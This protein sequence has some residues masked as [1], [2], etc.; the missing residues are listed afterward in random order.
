MADLRCSF[1]D[2]RIE[3]QGD[4]WVESTGW[5]RKRKSGGLNQLRD[6]TPTGRVACHSCIVALQHGVKV[7]KQERLFDDVE[8]QQF[9]HE[10]AKE[11]GQT[12]RPAA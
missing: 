10:D 6:R 2:K 7:G 3:S 11:P 4:I 1:C 5:H 8:P 9:P 12:V